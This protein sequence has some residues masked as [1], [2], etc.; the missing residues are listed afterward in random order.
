MERAR[1]RRVYSTQAARIGDAFTASRHAALLLPVGVGVNGGCG[2]VGVPGADGDLDGTGTLE[3]GA[4]VGCGRA[5]ASPVSTTG[6]T[7]TDDGGTLAELAT[8][9]G[10][11]GGG[12]LLGAA[13]IVAPV[14]LAVV[15]WP[16]TGGPA[17]AGSCPITKAATTAVAASAPAAAE[18][19]RQ[20]CRSIMATPAS[21]AIGGTRARPWRRSGSSSP[22]PASGGGGPSVARI[23]ASVTACRRSIRC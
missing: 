23:A 19:V 11:D 4:V 16:A 17:G 2:D 20:C 3:E 21:T 14:R 1:L 5:G 13:G 22:L 6:T 10:L 8:G 12:A 9:A 7:A 18:T 15:G